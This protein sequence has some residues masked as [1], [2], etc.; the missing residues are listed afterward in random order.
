MNRIRLSTILLIIL[1]AL[2]S[3]DKYESYYSRSF[4]GQYGII[5]TLYLRQDFVHTDE[6]TMILVSIGPGSKRVSLRSKGEDKTLFDSICEANGD[7]GYDREIVNV[8][9]TPFLNHIAH[10]P[11]ITQIDVVC[12]NAF[13]AEHPAGFSI[14]DLVEIRYSSAWE[15]INSGYQGI[16]SEAVQMVCDLSEGDLRILYERCPV[17]HL[18][19][20]P[21]GDGPFALTVKMTTSDGVERSAKI[22]I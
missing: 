11:D 2:S 19:K 5:D 12:N 18:T 20:L 22:T 9:K 7:I 14:S 6:I 21:E 13:D 17:L 4:I 8:S 3:C 1:F 15:Y 16:I 10:Y